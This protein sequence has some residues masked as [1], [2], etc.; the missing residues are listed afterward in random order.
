L[1]EVIARLAWNPASL[2]SW[3]S[4]FRSYAKV[5]HGERAEAFLAGFMPLMRA[6]NARLMN[7]PRKRLFIPYYLAP[8]PMSEL[9]EVK[10][11][12]RAMS[13]HG[14]REGGSFLFDRDLVDLMTWIVIRQ[15][16]VLEAEAYLLHLGGEQDKA[17]E[18]LDAAERT[19]KALQ[20]LLSQ[21]PELSI[22]EAARSAGQVAPLSERVVESF[23]V[24]ACDFYK[25]YPLVPSPE[26]IELV[27]RVQ[28]QNLRNL[29]EETHRRGEAATLE[30]PGWFWHDFPD[31][32][33]ADAVRML[34]RENAR[35]FEETMKARLAEAIAQSAQKSEEGNRV[36]PAAPSRLD[37]PSAAEAIV[38]ILGQG[39]PSPRSSLPQGIP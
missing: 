22:L 15:A 36:A 16:Q 3:E 37:Y 13:E 18:E 39:L 31:P 6:G 21:I 35:V 17:L 19:W 32:A 5:R 23:W 27:Y 8:E 11:G 7:P 34:P 24:Q 9:Q 38:E 26:A 12:A 1:S 30:A 10:E 25:G 14:H 28:L 20:D 2:E 33:W 4:V 29:L